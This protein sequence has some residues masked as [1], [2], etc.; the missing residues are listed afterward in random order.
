MMRGAKIF[1]I[2]PCERAP[3]AG[4]MRIAQEYHECNAGP[5]RKSR[6]QKTY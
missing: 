6:R 5:S 4:A 3:Q 2:G 1:K